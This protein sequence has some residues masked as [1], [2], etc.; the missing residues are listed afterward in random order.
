MKPIRAILNLPG[1]FRIACSRIPNTKVR[2]HRKTH[3]LMPIAECKSIH[4]R[5]GLSASVPT[6]AKLVSPYAFVLLNAVKV[7]NDPLSIRARRDCQIHAVLLSVHNVFQN[8]RGGGRY[9]RPRYR[10]SFRRRDRRI[11]HTSSGIPWFRYLKSNMNAF[12][13]LVSRR[14]SIHHHRL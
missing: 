13:V 8:V 9:K 2:A 14:S 4:N 6:F 10:W 3:L 12:S 11:F 7:T 5:C 1:R